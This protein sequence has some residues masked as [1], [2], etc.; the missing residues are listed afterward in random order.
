LVL[1]HLYFSSLIEALTDALQEV[2]LHASI[3]QMA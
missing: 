1:R 3:V 2:I